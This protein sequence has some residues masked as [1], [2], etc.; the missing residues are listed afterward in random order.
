MERC[1]KL[2]IICVVLESRVANIYI[3][4]VVLVVSKI[5]YGDKIMN[6]ITSS[7]CRAVARHSAPRARPGDAESTDLSTYRGFRPFKFE[8]HAWVLTE[9]DRCDDRRM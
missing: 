2:N 9:H 7:F 3:Y 1:K 6:L 4:I 5:M 8:F